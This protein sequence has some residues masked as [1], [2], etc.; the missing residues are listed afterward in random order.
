MRSTFVVDADGNLAA[1]MR[2]VDPVGHIPE[3]ERLI[4]ENL[5]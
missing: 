2:D 1:V 5:H 3:V 4:R